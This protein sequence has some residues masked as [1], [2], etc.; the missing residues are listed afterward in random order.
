MRILTLLA[1]SF[2]AL[3]SHTARAAPLPTLCTSEEDV[4]I[5]GETP[6]GFASLCAGKNDV[7]H[8]RFGEPGH[9]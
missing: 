1:L 2:V 4:V 5:S 8:Y 6:R 9:V 7:W 3:S